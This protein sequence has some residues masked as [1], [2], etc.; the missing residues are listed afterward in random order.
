M[1]EEKLEQE[2]EAFDFS[3]CHPVRE[4]LWDKLIAMHRADNAVFTDN[5]KRKWAAARLDEDELD[6]VAAAGQDYGNSKKRQAADEKVEKIW[7]KT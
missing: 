6:W 2:L 7:E 1:M 4:H 3:L 5:H